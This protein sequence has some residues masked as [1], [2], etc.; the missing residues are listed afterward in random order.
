MV[1]YLQAASLSYAGA[2]S[3]IPRLRHIDQNQGH[4]DF[5][6]YMLTIT[7]PTRQ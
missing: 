7:Q 4:R 1:N 6:P 5:Q 3:F 2:K